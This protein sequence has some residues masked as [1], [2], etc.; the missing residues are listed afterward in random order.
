MIVSLDLE[1]GEQEIVRRSTDLELDE[2]YVSVA[3]GDP[4]RRRRRPD[5]PRLLLRA[6]ESGVRRSAGRVA[7]ARRRSFTA[8]PPRT[9]RTRS[10]SACSSSRVAVSPWSTSTTE[11]ARVTAVS[12]ATA[13]EAA[14]ARST[15][16]TA[17][18]RRGI[19]SGRGD[20]D[21]ARIE[22]TGGSAG[23]YTTLMALAR[24]RRVR[25]RDVVLRRRR[26]RQLPRRDAQVRV[27]LR[28][29]PRR[30]LAR[31][32]EPLSRPVARHPRRLDRPAAAAPA[33]P[34]R[35]G[36]AAVAVRGDRRAP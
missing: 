33:G 21:A 28:R 19:S 8:A 2:S 6:E 1:S 12:T 34:R 29:V 14:G 30:A 20:A 7:A 9:S 11:A 23:G 3:R 36:R 17:P 27:A 24:A 26:S 25:R 18:R 16:R 15:S 4:V 22:I 31:S 10:T 32:D 13:C 35:Q 5:L